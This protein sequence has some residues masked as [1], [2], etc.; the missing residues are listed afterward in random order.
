MGDPNQ[1]ADVMRAYI[2]GWRTKN[3]T[4]IIEKLHALIQEQF[5]QLCASRIDELR[6]QYNIVSEPMLGIAESWVVFFP[7]KCRA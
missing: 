4:M 2:K 5:R 7:E 1:V 3:Q 6:W